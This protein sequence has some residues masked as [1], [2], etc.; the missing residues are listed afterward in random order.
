METN[1]P[2]VTVLLEGDV[3]NISTA[4]TIKVYNTGNTPALDVE[5]KAD[6]DCI[7]KI[8][9]DTAP[10]VFK[11]D[12]YACF[13]KKNTILV[14]HNNSYVENAFGL[15]SDNADNTLKCGEELPITIEYKN[16]Y[17]HRY[18]QKQTLKMQ[19]MDNF[20]GSTWTKGS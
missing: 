16:L 17:G 15:I 1:R 20:A 2:I 12:I 10:E 18:I 6:K 7:D 3:G 13:S 19:A 5:L 14:L 8:V 11:K 4:L 9:V